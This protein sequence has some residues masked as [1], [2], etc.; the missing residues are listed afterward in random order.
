MKKI[1]ITLLGIIALILVSCSGSDVYRGSW[2]ATDSQNSQFELNFD[3]KNFSVTDSSGKVETFNYTQNSVNIS[4][5]VSTYGIQLS[6]GRAFQITFPIPKKQT[7]ALMK[8]GNGVPV[9]A[10]SRDE[11]IK[12]EELYNL[13]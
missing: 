12:Y 10:I 7:V 6:D 3:A 9:F 11:Y 1:S 4:N 5:G 8:D 2:K 13:K